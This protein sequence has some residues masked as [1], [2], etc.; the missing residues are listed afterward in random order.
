MAEVTSG[1][2]LTVIVLDDDEA[3]ALCSALRFC[4]VDGD[5]SPEAHDELSELREALGVDRKVSA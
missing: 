1:A 5:P 3:G 2:Y 4:A